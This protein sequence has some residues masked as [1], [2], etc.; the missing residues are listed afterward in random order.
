MLMVFGIIGFLAVMV[1]VGVPLMLWQVTRRC[2]QLDPMSL[3]RLR[4]E[5]ELDPKSFRATPESVSEFHVKLRDQSQNFIASSEIGSLVTFKDAVAG[6]WKIETNTTG[7]T[8]DALQALRSVWGRESVAV[9]P[10]LRARLGDREEPGDAAPKPGPLRERLAEKFAEKVKELDTP[11]PNLPRSGFPLYMFLGF[12]AGALL[13]AGVAGLLTADA[14]RFSYTGFVKLVWSLGGLGTYLGHVA[15]CLKYRELKINPFGQITP[16][17]LGIGATI[18][19]L[20]SIVMLG[21]AMGMMT[22]LHGPPPH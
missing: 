19:L 1:V 22:V 11:S 4:Q 16:R 7:D 13:A 21:A 10:K 9:D 3:A 14:G 8:Q 20:G 5:A 17:I 15:G 18:V 6:N 12:T 2:R